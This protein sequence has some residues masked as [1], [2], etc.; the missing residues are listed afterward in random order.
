MAGYVAGVTYLLMCSVFT[1]YGIGP[2]TEHYFNCLTIWAVAVSVAAPRKRWA[3]AGL[4]LGLAFI[5]KPFAAAEAG[6]VGLYLVWHYGHDVPRML[7]R[8]LL[9]VGTWA[10]PLVGVVVYYAGHELLPELW[11]YSVEVS[12]AYGIELPWYLRLKYMADYLLRYSPLLLLAAGTQV[13]GKFGKAQWEWL[14]YLLLQFVLVTVVVLLT[15]KRYGHY[16]IQLHPAVALW[17]GATAGV[18]WAAVLRRQ[19]VRIAVVVL[20]VSIGLGHAAYYRGKADTDA[21][22]AAYLRPRLRAGET[23]F[24]LN[25]YQITYHLLDR[26]VPTPYAHPSLLYLEHN[27][28]ALDIDQKTVARSIIE[29]KSVKYLI[30]RRVDPSNDTELTRLLLEHFRVEGDVNGEVRVWIRE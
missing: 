24:P 2:N 15:G 22:V 23:Y 18:V 1:D 26:P 29:N 19:W 27:R 4:L 13:R 14:A 17:V 9:L 21:V 30:G 10:L 5:I 12:A 3:L 7:T 6:A 25:G 11:F 20:A 16:Q 28:R 8:G